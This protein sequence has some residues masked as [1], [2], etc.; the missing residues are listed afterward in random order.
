V[1]LTP[2]TARPVGVIVTWTTHDLLAVDMGRYRENSDVHDLMNFAL[3][4]VLCAMGW[5]TQPL[6]HAGAHLVT[7]RL[8]D[9]EPIDD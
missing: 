2:T 1:C 4:D 6:G 7:R 9:Q 3:A 8:G 5:A